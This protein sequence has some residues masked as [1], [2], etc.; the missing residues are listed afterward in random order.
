L[1]YTVGQGKKNLLT[2]IGLAYEAGEH[3]FDGAP[4]RI[5]GKKIAILF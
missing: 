5:A 2:F 3:T 1:N 4:N